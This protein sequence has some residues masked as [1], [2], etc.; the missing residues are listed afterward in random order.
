[1]DTIVSVMLAPAMWVCGIAFWFNNGWSLYR[2]Q[3]HSRGTSPV[4]SGE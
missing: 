2:S 3:P 4:H 1:M